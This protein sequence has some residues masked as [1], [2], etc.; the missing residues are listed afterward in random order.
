MG[1]LLSVSDGSRQPPKLITWSTTAARK[2]RSPWSLVGKGVTFDTGGISSEAQAEMDE[3]KY[4][5]SGAGSVLGTMSAI[6]AMK[7][8]A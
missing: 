7:L 1:S 2:S 5:M 6:A 4:D 3:M 8:A